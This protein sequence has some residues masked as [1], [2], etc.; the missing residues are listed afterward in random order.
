MR[1]IVQKFACQESRGPPP[2]SRRP[3]RLILNEAF[4]F[5]LSPDRFVMS[6]VVSISTH[7]G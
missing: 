5:G 3:G 4:T 1:V 6:I 7:V 2:P